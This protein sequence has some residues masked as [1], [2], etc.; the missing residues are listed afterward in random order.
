MFDFSA[1]EPPNHIPTVLRVLE[2]SLQRPHYYLSN[3][4]IQI[5]DPYV[6][7]LLI[8]QANIERTVVAPKRLDADNILK[9][10]NGGGVAWAADFMRVHRYAEGGGQ[11]IKLHRLPPND[12]RNMMFT[13]SD[14]ASV[15]R[16][17]DIVRSHNHVKLFCSTWQGNLRDA[18]GECKAAQEEAVQLRQQFQTLTR[19]INGM[20][21]GLLYS[22]TLHHS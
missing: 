11:S 8:N 16:F 13:S 9:R 3:S 12:P 22:S 6:L 1:G 20:N 7:R 10:M 21:V 4:A 18:E 2:V 5:T 15:L 17:V 14:S 19:E